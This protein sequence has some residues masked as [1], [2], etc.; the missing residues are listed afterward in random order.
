MTATS[1][2]KSIGLQDGLLMKRE[3]E[4]G[5]KD[6]AYESDLQKW[7]ASLTRQEPPKENQAW[8]ERPW[9]GVAGDLRYLLNI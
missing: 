5:V 1:Q 7:I 6:D 3:G 2:V 4:N 8:K 9:F